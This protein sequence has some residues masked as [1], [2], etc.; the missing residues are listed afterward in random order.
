MGVLGRWVLPR[1]LIALALG[2]GGV[3]PLMAA[4]PAG[5]PLQT[6]IRDRLFNSLKPEQRNGLTKASPIDPMIGRLDLQQRQSAAGQFPPLEKQFS[7]PKSL[8]EI[9]TVYLKLGA[10]SEAARLAGKLKA[11]YPDSA[12]GSMLEAKAKAESGD[13]AGALASAKAA[14]MQEPGNAEVIAYF[15]LLRNGGGQSAKVPAAEA[16][17]TTQK[18]RVDSGNPTLGPQ[19]ERRVNEAL[20]KLRTSANGKRILVAIVPDSN[21]NVTEADLREHGVTIIMKAEEAKGRNFGS[22]EKDGNTYKVLINV[23]VLH[24]ANDLRE[25]AA[26]MGGKFS[27]VAYD[28]KN[29][30]KTSNILLEWWDRASQAV[31]LIDFGVEA[32]ASAKDSEFSQEVRLGERVFQGGTTH[33]PLDVARGEDYTP[34]N[35]DALSALSRTEKSYGEFGLEG[36][37]RMMF[38][39]NPAQAMIGSSIPA[40]KKKSFAA[41]ISREYGLD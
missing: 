33:K 3:L 37:L 6:A 13:T 41:E 18:G 1:W 21:G 25:Q 7:D 24:E 12:L 22:V 19:F 11:K 15:K 34:A 29:G 20:A 36:I 26:F 4:G 16:A 40:D 38:I 8:S 31:L 2:I 27:Q 39:R 17:P 32:F 23:A 9:G 14:A 28:K 5:D 10:S 35:N 30:G